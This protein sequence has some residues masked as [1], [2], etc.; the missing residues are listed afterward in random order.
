MH[1]I[2]TGYEGTLSALAEAR[3]RV[4]G[5]DAARIVLLVPHPVSY[6]APPDPDAAAGISEQYRLL[7][8]SAGVDAVVRVC[9]CRKREDAFRWMLGKRSVV[10]MGG[11]HRW[12][13]PTAAQQ[14]ARWL[15]KAGHDVVFAAL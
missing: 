13:W 3:R 2:A 15:K 1:V 6:A 10:V 14:M 12:W 5:V 11:R 4:Y 9:F 8:A 7:A